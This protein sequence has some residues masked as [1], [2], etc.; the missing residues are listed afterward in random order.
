[1]KT[2]NNTLRQVKIETQLSKIYG[3]WKNGSEKEVHSNTSLP[4]EARKISVE[5]PNFPTKGISKRMEYYSV[6]K[7]N[8]ILFATT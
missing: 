3:T 6:I 2:D 7:N 4:Q 1:M 8:E 5:Q